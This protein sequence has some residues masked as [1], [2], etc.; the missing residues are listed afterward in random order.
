MKKL[1]TLSLLALLS[2]SMMG[3][4]LFQTYRR[5]LS[6]PATYVCYRTDGK[7][8]IDGKLN[9]DCWQ[10]A[11]PTVPFSDISGEGYAAPKYRTTAKMLW[12]DDYLYVAAILE[13][14]DLKATLKE[15]DSVIWRDNDFEVFLDPDG[16]GH[17]YFEIEVNALGTLFE[18]MLNKPY[19]SGGDFFTQWDCPG[20]QSA[21]R[22]DGSLN[23]SKD[24]DKGWTVEMAIPHKALTRS[25]TNPLKAGNTWRIN[26]SRVQW[27]KPEGPEE[28][29]V[30]T[31]TGRIDM[32]MPDRWAYL[33][34]SDQK[35]GSAPEEFS[36]PYDP[37]IYKLL[38]AMFYAQQ[39]Q[40]KQTKNYM[41]EVEQ[42]VLTEDELGV[43]PEK[44]EIKVEATQNTFRILIDNPVEKKRYI[45]DN[46]GCF[47]LEQIPPKVVK[48]WMWMRFGK[49][50]DE[51][52]REHFALIRSCGISA[53][54][55]EGYNEHIYQLC[56]EAGLE[57]HYW[58]WTLNRGNLR[59]SHPEWYAVNRKGE[60]S[61]DK[62]AY[63]DYYRFLCP[64]QEG[65]AEYLAEDYVK[66]AHLPYVD[67]VHLDYIRFPDVILP[68]GLW[69]NYGI[70]Q[71][72]ELPEYDYCYCEVCRKKF[73][74]MTGRDPLEEPY[75]SADD[76]WLRFRLNSITNVVN[77]ISHA[78]KLEHKFISSAVFPGPSMA[79]K[80]VRQDW[81]NWNLD[82]FFPMIYNKFYCEGTEWIGDCVK[83]SVEAVHGKAKIYAGLFFPDIRDTFEEALDEAY[84]NGADG[85]SFF[86]GPN[87][88][89]LRRFK[90]Y[91]DS[92]NMVA[93]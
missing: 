29:W 69:K 71:I 49:R 73:K 84:G 55:F 22:L 91:L 40:F 16:N 25:F 53:V 86:D 10:K 30:W 79:R 21:V 50:T 75:P 26:F 67:G 57:A 9:E 11:A 62:P 47:S 76:S 4:S 66:E 77:T 80:M 13:E 54:L 8:K 87:E 23:K 27:L 64:N 28:N 43:L 42:F 7:I 39:D 38:W 74:E 12:D 20:L 78:V 33:Q 45:V 35:A 52:W 41:R 18:L 34:F 48:N 90:A 32:H 65:L 19:R 93:E 60:S 89:G 14:P 51:Q 24:T 17:D 46:E 2:L 56:K 82:A 3:Q 6:D 83:E 58:K 5:F 31:P 44:A 59:E 70:E 36:Y 88:E 72:T 1:I 63:V 81:N 15:H 85:I 92:H 61:C 37:Q 68:T